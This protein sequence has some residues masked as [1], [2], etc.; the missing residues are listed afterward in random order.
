[1]PESAAL[2]ASLRSRPGIL[3]PDF[4]EYSQPMV[5]LAGP[6]AIKQPAIL[7]VFSALVGDESE[8]FLLP[9]DRGREVAGF[10]IS[11]GQGRQGMRPLSNG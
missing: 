5:R 6:I 9:L 8:G 2:V 3:D 7:M 4:L 11:G 1:M 10:R